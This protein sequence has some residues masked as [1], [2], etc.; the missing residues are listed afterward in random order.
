MTD[1][2]QLPS[3]DVV[4]LN[5]VDARVV[6]AS[7]YPQPVCHPV[8]AALAHVGPGG[9]H[10]RQGEG[11]ARTGYYAWLRISANPRWRRPHRSSGGC[12]SLLGENCGMVFDGAVLL[13]FFFTIVFLS[14]FLGNWAFPSIL[15]NCRAP[16]QCF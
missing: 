6:R 8:A 5:F 11:G 2:G 3:P 1:G 4:A 10:G 14:R 15:G 7:G 13:F 12:L 9:Q 16:S